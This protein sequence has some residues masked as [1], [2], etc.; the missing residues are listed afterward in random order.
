MFITFN[1]MQAFLLQ[2]PDTVILISFTLCTFTTFYI[3]TVFLYICDLFK[4]DL[5]MLNM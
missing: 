3:K 1:I 4:V 2:L 5:C